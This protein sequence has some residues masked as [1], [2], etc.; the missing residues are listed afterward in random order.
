MPLRIAIIGWGSLIWD[1]RALPR[2]GP[3]QTGGPLLPVEFSR[4]SSDCRLTLVIDPENGV[5]TRTRFV[6]SPRTDLF[7]AIDD[8]KDREGTV[9]EHIGHIG[10]P[11]GCDSRQDHDRVPLHDTI[12]E[13]ACANGFDAAV[14]TA[15]PSNF[16]SKTGLP[17]SIANAI[18]YLTS[19]PQTVRLKALRYVDNAP[20]EVITPLRQALLENPIPCR[21][22]P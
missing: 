12:A 1:P 19:L 7:D 8:L 16:S 20:A 6:L 3:W 22:R 9:R 5:H 10:C 2:E 11:P 17:F 18:A 14:W 21:G 4:V 15:L 13:W